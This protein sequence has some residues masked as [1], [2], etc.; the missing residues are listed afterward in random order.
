M[1]ALLAYL[2]TD[3]LYHRK[4]QRNAIF[5]SQS[6]SENNIGGP[7]KIHYLIVEF[8]IIIL[9]NYLVFCIYIIL[10][11]FWRRETIEPAATV[12]QKFCS[13]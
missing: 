4:T 2:P 7:P 12:K 10:Y 9:N 13:F 5:S 11:Q 3:R 8:S 1:P 6:T